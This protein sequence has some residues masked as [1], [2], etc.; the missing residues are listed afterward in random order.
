MAVFKDPII[1]VTTGNIWTGIWN[2]SWPMFVMMIFGFMVGFTDVYVAGLIS[3]NVQA[4]VGFITQIY[5]LVIIVANAI[6]IGS[7][8]VISRAIGAGDQARAIDAAKQSLLLGLLISIAFTAVCVIFYRSIISAAGFPQEITAIAENFL[9]IFAF[10]LGPNYLLIIS[11]TVFR[12]G[13]EVKKPLVTMFVISV[14]NIA[15]DF[16]LVFGIPPFPRLGY[17]G[18]AFSTAISTLLGT[19]MNLMFLWFSEKWRPVYSDFG[20]VSFGMIKTIFNTGWPAGFL[21]V[22]WNLASIFL[23]NVLARLKEASIIALASIANGLRIEAIIFLPAFALNMAASVIVGQNLGAGDPDR[24]ERIGWKLAGLG[25]AVTSIMAIVIFI[26]AESFASTLTSEPQVLAETARYLRFNMVSEP[27]LALSTVMGGGLQGAGDTRATMW[28][29]IISMWL[30]RLPLAV[31]LALYAGLGAPGVWTAMVVSM[32][33]Q[34]LMMA[35]WFHKG[36]WKRLE[37]R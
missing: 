5:F 22:A 11:N 25:I 32:A 24:A 15:L 18:I 19:V 33:C 10:A 36:R 23:Y 20:T 8:A 21:Q 35:W 28:V 9:Q 29:I 12:A 17:A 4:A 30:I 31:Y 37:L 3:P 26:W 2:L 34:G 7:L 13:A 27:F 6:S 1:N 16:L 14:I